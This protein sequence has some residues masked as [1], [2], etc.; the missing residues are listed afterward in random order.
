MSQLIDEYWSTRLEKVRDNLS[1]N[2]FNAFVAEDEKEAIKVVLE[3]IIPLLSPKVLS[4][5][6]S[7]TYKE[8]GLY[9]ILKDKEEFQIIDTFEAGL[10]PEEALERRRQALL[11]DLY[12]TGTN[13]VT[14]DGK[15]VNL[16][17]IGNR[18]GAITFGQKM[19]LYLLVEIKYPKIS[20]LLLIVLEIMLHL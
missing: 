5:G 10:Q 14:E 6:G 18:V 4:W 3:D 20:I 15:L 19:L 8:S 17:M 1:A 13:A 2:N 11:S 16:D 9:E 12:I 7:M